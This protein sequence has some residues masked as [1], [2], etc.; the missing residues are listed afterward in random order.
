MTVNTSVQ[1]D[2]AIYSR[3]ELGKAIATVYGTESA[4]FKI[5]SSAIRDINPQTLYSDEAVDIVRNILYNSEYYDDILAALF[6]IYVEL[7]S[8]GDKPV[9]ELYN[10]L[11]SSEL[12]SDLHK[13]ML[14][15]DRVNIKQRSDKT[16]KLLELIVLINIHK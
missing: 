10:D 4:G 14:P 6:R 12:I 1:E 7:N 8:G 13:I 11:F 3:E 15:K 16:D 2:R 9:L 5:F